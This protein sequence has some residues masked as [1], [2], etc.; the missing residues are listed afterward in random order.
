MPDSA[1]LENLTWFER[2]SVRLV[3]RMHQGRW[4]RLWCWCQREIGA[5]WISL[6]AGPL[7]EV[8]GLEHVRATS[9]ERPLVV[10]PNHRTFFD[11]YVVSTVLFRRTGGWR[12]LNFPVRGRYFYQRPGGLLVN[13]LAAF[14]AMY[15]PF[16]LSS[17]RRRFDQWALRELVAL[18]R[19]GEGRLVGYHPEGTRNQGDDPWSLLPPHPGIGRLIHE[20]RPTV[21]PVFIGGLTHDILALL[22]RRRGGEQIRIWFGPPLDYA[23][24]LEGP[25]SSATYRALA[26]RV[27]AEVAR[28]AAADRALHGRSG[29]EP[30]PEGLASG[31]SS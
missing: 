27:M 22:R 2:L 7:F 30:G 4:P 23:D 21:V 1:P 18:C 3:R 31:L 10:V 20:A 11:L 25:P 13:F 8:H 5:R 17:A 16:F 26:E 9:R 24:L 14:W 12:A 15:P 19:E 6:L 29:P 28:L